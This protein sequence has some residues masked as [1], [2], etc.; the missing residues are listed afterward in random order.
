MM[1]FS[2]LLLS[3]ILQLVITVVTC[4][5]SLAVA[6][7][8]EGYAIVTSSAIRAQSTMLNAFV[9]HKQSRGFNTYVFDENDWSAGGLTGDAAAEALRTF[10]QQA[11]NQYNL[12]Y[13]LIIGDP[14]V[15]T[16]PV[17]MKRTY[18]RTTGAVGQTPSF[19]TTTCNFSQSQVPSDFYYAELGG[20][21]DLDND[22]LYGEFG[23]ASA[24]GTTT[25]DFGV[26]GVE[27][28]YDLSVGRI[29]TYG[30]SNNPSL[31]ADGII[32]LD[33]ILTKIINYQT[34]SAASIDWRF[35]ALIA[36][37][38][39][40]R[41]FYGEALT[42]D[43]FSPQGITAVDRIYDSASCTLAG[44]CN[45][46]LSTAPT[47][48]Q[49]TIPN[50]QTTLQSQTPGLVTWL[51]HG[52]G[53][54]AAAVMNTSTAAS[55]DDT[56]PFITFQASCLNSQVTNTNNL[57]YSLLVNGAIATVGATAIS[58]GPGSPVDLT[59]DAHR[60]GIA[61]MGYEFN[62][63]VASGDSVGDALMG[64]KQDADL[65]GRCW[66]WQN[67]VGFNL[68][69]DPEVRLFD[70]GSVSVPMVPPAFM[71]V[72]GVMLLLVSSIVTGGRR[73]LK[74]TV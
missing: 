16:G 28:D 8:A 34:V 63:R 40:N 26:G 62:Q 24:V 22:G 54:G 32:K 27:L 68:F 65:Y 13:L 74:P 1:H 29:P 15:D 6:Q 67:Q 42:N 9:A 43:V 12:R 5:H 7:S 48:D 45:P 3:T 46:L 53:T 17:P 49:C 51:T 64:V 70:S 61:G 10:L 18:P 72:A 39:A 50:V 52:G 60:S 2:A 56:K 21:W 57:S 25:G 69:G 47:Y 4:F 44:N 30:S 19:G 37:E 73:S 11:N 31:L 35:S 14:R 66:Y 36:T 23:Q 33:H 58:H 20:D 71:F 59:S 55:L 38:G 41:L